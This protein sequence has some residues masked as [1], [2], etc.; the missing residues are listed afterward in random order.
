MLELL[1]K[2]NIHTSLIAAWMF[3]GPGQSCCNRGKDKRVRITADASVR[4]H[5]Q[6]WN[7]LPLS[8]PGKRLLKMTSWDTLL[9]LSLCVL[10]DQIALCRS[11]SCFLNLPRNVHLE[12]VQL[13]S[14]LLPCATVPTSRG[15]IPTGW[16]CFCCPTDV[17]GL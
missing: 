3:I 2:L 4:I 11:L 9:I 7:C 1:Y 13:A 14:L 16:R 15:R 6:T 10:P 5:V 12:Q 17:A 8:Q